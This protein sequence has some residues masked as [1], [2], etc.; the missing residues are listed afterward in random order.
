MVRFDCARCGRW[1]RYSLARLAARYGPEHDLDGVLRRLAGDCPR[2]SE[3]RCGARMVDLERA[4][5][6]PDLPPEPGHRRRQPAREDAPAPRAPPRQDDTSGMPMLSDW[7]DGRDVVITCRKC[8]RR[9]VHDRDDLL[10]A[11]GDVTLIH[12]RTALTSD[13]P[14]RDAARDQDKCSTSFE[15]WPP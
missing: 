12:L 8:G 15:G 1:G 11:S 10:S 3:S 5:R 4:L 14:R 9:D 6:P 2:Q 7:P 13:C